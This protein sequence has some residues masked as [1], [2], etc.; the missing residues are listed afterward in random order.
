MPTPN[1]NKDVTVTAAMT[2]NRDAVLPWVRRAGIG[3]RTTD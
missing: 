1:A 3:G 2:I